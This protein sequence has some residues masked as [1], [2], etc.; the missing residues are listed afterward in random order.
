MLHLTVGYL[1]R[2]YRCAA[3]CQQKEDGNWIIVIFNPGD[4]PDA[5]D[6]IHVMK[7][8]NIREFTRLGGAI[9]YLSKREDCQTFTVR[10]REGPA[11]GE[12]YSD[13]MPDDAL[14]GDAL[15]EDTAPF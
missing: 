7:G 3:V 12:G 13:A 14:P 9:N 2:N 6:P 1:V 11:C 10:G 5:H 4:S 15:P 8:K